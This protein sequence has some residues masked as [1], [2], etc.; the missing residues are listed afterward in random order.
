MKRTYCIVIFLV[1]TVLTSVCLH[2]HYVDNN[3]HERAKSNYKESDS[4]SNRN[5]M[6]TAFCLD[7]KKVGSHIEKKMFVNVDEFF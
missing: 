4:Y 6:N 7:A 5:D 1:A 2:K 3:A